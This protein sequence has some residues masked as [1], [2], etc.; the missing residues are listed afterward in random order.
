MDSKVISDR[1]LLVVC[2]LLLAC[3]SFQVIDVKGMD[4]HKTL[5]EPFQSSFHNL[6]HS[7]CVTLYNRVGRIG[8]GT[9]DRDAQ[10]GPIYY[11][12][13]NNGVPDDGE[14]FVAVIEEYQMT[15]EIVNTLLSSNVNGNLKGI[16]VLNGT[17]TDESNEHASPGPIYPLGYGTPSEGISYGYNDYA[18]NANGDGLIHND[19]YGVP[20]IY[21]NEYD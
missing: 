5:N 9:V 3:L 2:L 17:D 16:M 4:K 10:S 8:C 12:D 1:R 11:Y 14:N 6:K 15:A 21:I 19:L 7:P 20:M 13:G 18:W